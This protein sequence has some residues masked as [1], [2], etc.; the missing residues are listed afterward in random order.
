MYTVD[1]ALRL[2]LDAIRQMPEL[3]PEGDRRRVS[4]KQVG[5][6][7]YLRIDE[8]VYRVD[9]RY[10]YVVGKNDEWYELALFNLGDCSTTYLEWYEDDGLELSLQHEELSLQDVGVTKEMLARFDDDEA[11]RFVFRGISYVYKE[12]DAAIFYRDPEDEGEKLYYW[13]F[14]GSDST[15]L[16]FER[17]GTSEYKVYLSRKLPQVNVEILALKGEE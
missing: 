10:R 7:G 2:R 12:S 4:V 17:W 3:L 1:P 16:G 6:G 9:G 8:G 11:G 14:K 5:A 15:T 13:D